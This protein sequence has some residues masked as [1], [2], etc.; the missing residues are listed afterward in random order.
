MHNRRP[1]CSCLSEK[2]TFKD[3]GKACKK[4]VE[5]YEHEAAQDYRF[6]P[7]LKSSCEEDIRALCPRLCA[8]NDGNVSVG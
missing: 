7:R 5:E 8:E 2:K 4:E 1:P 3:F 6:N